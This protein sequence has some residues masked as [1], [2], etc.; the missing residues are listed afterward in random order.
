MKRKISFSIRFLVRIKP[1][2]ASLTL[3]ECACSVTSSKLAY[4]RKSIN[5]ACFIY[6]LFVSRCWWMALIFIE[7][8]KL[9]IGQCRQFRP[10]L[11]FSFQSNANL[12]DYTWSFWS[13]NKKK[14]RCCNC[15]RSIHTDLF[16]CIRLNE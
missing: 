12:I 5:V 3:A 15:M 6:F 2:C 8:P 9:S 1:N 16:S 14:I 13:S 10:V 11:S 4:E 7:I